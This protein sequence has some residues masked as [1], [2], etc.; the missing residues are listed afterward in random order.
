MTANYNRGRNLLFIL[1]GL[2]LLPWVYIAYNSYNSS[3][4]L[5][6]NLS[7]WPILYLVLMYFA[8]KGKNWAKTSLSAFL[9]F[10]MLLLIIRPFLGEINIDEIYLG[11]YIFCING[12]IVYQL[13]TNSNISTFLTNSTKLNT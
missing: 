9:V 4:T 6:S 2:M 8:Y 10:G 13:N 1:F 5:F 12:L 11:I 3:E 7:T